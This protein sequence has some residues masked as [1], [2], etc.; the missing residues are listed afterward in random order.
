[1][2]N[3][4]AEAFAPATVANLGV[5]FDLLG[6]A[7][8]G[9][10][11]QVIC[12]WREDGEI[13][14]CDIQGDAGR[15]PREASKNVASVAARALLDQ[16]GI[17]RGVNLWLRKGLPPASGLGS[18]AASAVA[19]V[20]AVNA[21]MGDP[22]ARE[23]LLPAALEGEAVA[24]GGYHADNVAPS[25]LGG[26]TLTLGAEITQIERLPVPAGMCLA[27][28]TPD[29][30]VPT[31]LARAALPANISIRQMV[32]QT[33]AVASLISAL[34]RGDIPAIARAME[35]DE[36]VEPARQHLMPMLADIRRAA[37]S[38]GALAL[39][40]SGAGPSLCALCD[41]LYVAQN[42]S[43]CMQEMYRSASIISRVRYSPVSTDGARVISVD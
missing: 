24:S 34:Y 19:A 21:L 32:H 27:V 5:G 8:E 26:I 16:C 39:V 13:V 2:S 10:G 22:L 23:S 6:L 12:E 17:T 20:V 40:I 42:V 7:I 33:G 31:A 1:M 14:I 18:S 15:L 29:V 11:D 37:K 35:A 38:E 28:V 25:L 43:V 36:V 3:A 4:R 9:D 41:D 30:E